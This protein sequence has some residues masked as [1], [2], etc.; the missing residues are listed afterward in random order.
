MKTIDLRKPRFEELKIGD[1]VIT[2]KGFTFLKTK[3]GFLDQ[4]TKLE[5]RQPEKRK[6]NH[7]DATKKY[8]SSKKR[9][10]TKGEF[11]IGEE[12]G[13]REV[14]DLSNRWFWSS[15]G[16]PNDPAVAYF[17]NGVN[18]GIFSGDRSNG[19]GSVVCVGGR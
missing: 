16:N 5:W 12:H 4:K 14:L 8:S 18:G 9:L 13:I 2:S 19:N 10:P 17:F 3:S 1:R 11:E 7:D 6:Y 15:S